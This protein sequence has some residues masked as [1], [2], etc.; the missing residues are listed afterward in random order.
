[1]ALIDRR[2][3]LV[4]LAALSLAA[5]NKGGAGASADEMSMGDPKAK[6][7]VIEYASVACPICAEVNNTVFPEFKKKYIDTNKVHYVFREALTGNPSLAVAGFLLARCAGKDKYFQVTDAVFRAQEQIYEP[8]SENMRPQVGHDILLNIGKSVGVSE[9]QFN[10]CM[11]DE[12]SITALQDR[13][14]RLSK[15]YDVNA[16][17]TFVINGKVM[18]RGAMSLAELDAAIQPLLK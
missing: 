18:N 5:C 13:V 7:T 3:L 8:G 4:A 16:T 9:Q 17:P 6:V 14:E 10:T 1:M 11:N 12:K 2:L 15:Q